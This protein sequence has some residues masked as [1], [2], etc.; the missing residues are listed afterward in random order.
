MIIC[1]CNN[2][3]ESDI[4]H[5]KLRYGKGYLAVLA[6]NSICGNCVKYCKKTANLTDHDLCDIIESNTD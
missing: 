3:D 2:L 1:I 4:E 6:L 5:L